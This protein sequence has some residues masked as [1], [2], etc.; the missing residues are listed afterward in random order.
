MSSLGFLTVYS[1]I[2]ARPNF[3]C[4]RFFY[5]PSPE[6]LP[7]SFESRR[8]L[9]D[10]PV[11][12]ASISYENDYW[13]FLDFLHRIG[14]TEPKSPERGRHL[15]VAGGVAPW[16]NP[17]PILPITD[18]VLTGEGEA[19]LNDFLDVVGQRWFLELPKGEM[20]TALSE[21]VRGALV[22]DSLPFMVRHGEGADFERA[23]AAFAP[24]RPPRLPYP[25]PQGLSP[26]ASPI[27][28]K[29][30]EF[31]GAKLIEISRGCPY[32][33]RFCLAGSL[34]RPHRPWEKSRIMEAAS[35]ANPW[36]WE[37]AFPEK[38]PVGLVSPAVGD[39]P[40][41]AEMVE[42]FIAQGRKVSFSSLRLSALTPRIVELFAKGRVKGIA[43]AP[44]AGGEGL[45]ERLNKSLTDHDI[46]EKVKAL[47]GSG[48]TS[49]KLYFMI[50]LP[51]ES[52]GDLQ[53]ICD[54]TARVLSALRAKKG[55][56]RV[57]VSCSY[58]VP[59]PHTPFEDEPLIGEAEM[60]RRG[61]FLRG[62][63]R[64]LGGAALR[65]PPPAESV[66]QGLLS[67]GGPESFS[68]VDTLRAVRGRNKAALK[69]IG[70]G[71]PQSV[72]RGS[73]HLRPWRIVAP[74][75]GTGFL[76]SEKE[77]AAE[78]VSTPPCP[79]GL[80]CGRCGACGGGAE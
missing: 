55:A 19:S 68:L 64:A 43:L 50:G 4:E 25:F 48:L 60:R 67:R 17:Y 36:D 46:L 29:D 57:A 34:Y 31:S 9:S 59:K 39:H 74:G 53:A 33:C 56:P 78:G 61:E 76:E 80:G 38:A 23:L 21:N 18:A 73:L 41:F 52:D 8:R 63:M 22:P 58:F 40:E 12:C 51:G 11:I 27:W 20:L 66:V 26:P 7:L 3:L 42:E 49:L 45:R 15:I 2:S 70:W 10:F 77:K 32:G 37:P 75:I 28:T 1:L 6:A 24:I 30:T 14:I 44:E 71:G 65:L 54:L 62:R 5:D 72:W 35:A 13:I 16:S 69:F 79:K 47:A